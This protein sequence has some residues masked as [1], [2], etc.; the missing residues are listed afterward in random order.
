AH[1]DVLNVLLQILDDGRVT[2]AQGRTVNFEN[3]VIIMTTNAG[4]NRKTGSVGFGGSLSDMSRERSMKALS[5]FLRPE[6]LNRVD[7]VVCFNPLTEENFRGIA[8][9]MLGEVRDLLAEK[10]IALVWD[11]SLVDHLVRTAYSLTYGARNLRRTIQ[12][13]IEDEIAAKLVEA[14]GAQTSGISLSAADG[15]VKIVLS[16]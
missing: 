15:K 11:D 7:E 4:S 6:F 16:A 12:K 13:E 2:D 3:T 1:P 14:R 9:L 10:N 5:E 8:A